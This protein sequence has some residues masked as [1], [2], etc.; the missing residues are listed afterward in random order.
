MSV[1]MKFLLGMSLFMF[2]MIGLHFAT[3]FG[4]IGHAPETRGGLFIRIGIIM[5]I[6]IIVSAVLAG[7]IAARKGEDAIEPDEREQLILTKTERNGGY[8]LAVGLIGLMWFVFDGMSAMNVANAALAVLAL[9]EAVKVASA[10]V[11]LSR[12]T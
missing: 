6:F 10:L 1:N 11:Y 2:A 3:V 4:Q 9:G 5:G 12:G 8:G 7:T